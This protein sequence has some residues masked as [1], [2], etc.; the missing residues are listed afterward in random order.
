[1]EDIIQRNI[2]KT[3]INSEFGNRR[4]AFILKYA[5]MV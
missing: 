4:N 1:M 5:G 3:D 2:A